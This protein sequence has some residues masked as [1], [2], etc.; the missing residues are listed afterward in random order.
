MVFSSAHS[1]TLLLEKSENAVS[2][3]VNAIIPSEI[4][5]PHT[6][7]GRAFVGFLKKRSCVSDN[8]T[9][10]S[11]SLAPAAAEYA[12]NFNIILGAK[13]VSWNQL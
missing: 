7:E 2:D 5:E 12:L 3:Y 11:P 4:S 10:D 6:C 13:V 8:E 1:G 9:L